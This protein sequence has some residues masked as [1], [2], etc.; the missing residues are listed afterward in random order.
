MSTLALFAGF[1]HYALPPVCLPGKVAV[2][3]TVPGPNGTER[4]DS[5][6]CSFLDQEI[7]FLS[8]EQA[9][10]QEKLRRSVIIIAVPGKKFNGYS[11]WRCGE[12]QAL[13]Y[14]AGAIKQFDCGSS[15]Q[16]E[17]SRYMAG[18]IR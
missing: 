8:L 7:H 13:I 12:Y 2:V 6:F 16:P 1:Q 10:K 14:K 11:L 15:L 18:F 9:L 5:Q 17:N 4:V 3:F